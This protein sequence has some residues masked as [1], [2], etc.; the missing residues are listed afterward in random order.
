MVILVVFYLLMGAWCLIAWQLTQA[1]ALA[2]G[3]GRYGHQLIP[4]VLLGLGALILIDS[5]TL[6]HRG[7][8]VFSLC[9]VGLMLSSVGRQLRQMAHES[10]LLAH[11]PRP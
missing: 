7:L 1:P 8:A 6:D 5:H 9:C 4:F 2:D 11:L 3:L 10:S